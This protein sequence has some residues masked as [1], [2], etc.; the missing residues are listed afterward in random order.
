MGLAPQVSGW[1]SPRNGTTD[2]WLEE[3]KA[4]TTGVAGDAGRVPQV[5]GWRGPRA[6]TTG[7]WLK[8]QG[9]YHRFVAGGV[10]GLVPQASG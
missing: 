6:G 1:R 3:S 8:M 7:V 9:W 2:E 4:D 10:R 5:C